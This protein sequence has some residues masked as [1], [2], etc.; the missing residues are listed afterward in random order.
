MAGLSAGDDPGRGF[1]A[2]NHGVPG[3]I[4]ER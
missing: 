4:R 1:P 3:R 2:G